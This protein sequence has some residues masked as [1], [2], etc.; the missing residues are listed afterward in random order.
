MLGCR[1]VVESSQFSFKC[2]SAESVTAQIVFYFGQQLGEIARFIQVSMNTFRQRMD[3][4][5]SKECARNNF[6]NWLAF[7]S[8]FCDAETVTQLTMR[9]FLRLEVE[10]KFGASCSSYFLHVPDPIFTDQSHEFTG[11]SLTT[12]CHDFFGFFSFSI[13]CCGASSCFCM[14]ILASLSCLTRARQPVNAPPV[15][16][17]IIRPTVIN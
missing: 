8:V 7:L 5:E 12:L 9:L 16:A 6:N 10:Q 15:D 2:N 17:S 1:R 14:T 3:N 4:I 13:F 11:Y